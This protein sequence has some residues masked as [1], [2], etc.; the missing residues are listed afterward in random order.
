MTLTPSEAASAFLN[1]VGL[2]DVTTGPESAGANGAV[3]LNAEA[4]LPVA[5]TPA[6]SMA[7][8]Q[9]RLTN[10]VT[11]PEGYTAPWGQSKPSEVAFYKD[12]SFALRIGAARVHVAAPVL[13]QERPA[14]PATAKAPRAK[15]P[16][17][18]PA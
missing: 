12:G 17:A 4:K 6:K 9:A 7:E 5:S 10:A 18:Q 11:N 16:V 8:L 13:V 3:W 14:Q 2:K 1:H 15:R